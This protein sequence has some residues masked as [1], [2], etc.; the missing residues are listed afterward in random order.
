MKVTLGWYCSSQVLLINVEAS[1]ITGNAPPPPE[2]IE[3]LITKAEIA[4]ITALNQSQPKTNYKFMCSK[5]PRKTIIW[6]H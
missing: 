6:L 3:N 5:H 1:T 2:T 4:L